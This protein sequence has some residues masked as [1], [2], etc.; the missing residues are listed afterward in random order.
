MTGSKKHVDPAL[1]LYVG[2]HVICTIDK[3]NL[4]KEV[5]GGNGTLC[6][7]IGLKLKDNSLSYRWKNF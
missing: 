3:V 1:C 6:H 4:N 5:P 7:V 2:A